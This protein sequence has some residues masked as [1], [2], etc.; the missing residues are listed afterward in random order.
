MRAL[1]IRPVWAWAIIFGGK[2]IENRTW[3]TNHRGPLLIHTSG[4]LAGANADAAVIEDQHGLLVPD[5]LDYGCT[6]GIVDLVDCVRGHRSR[7]AG[8]DCW[9]WVLANPRP[10]E[11][12]DCKGRLNLWTF[13][14]ERIKLLTP[15]KR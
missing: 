1:T 13:P 11:T 6:L 2:D 12:V 4:T 14:D 9:N 8:S 3:S 5:V 10:V 15:G 7:W